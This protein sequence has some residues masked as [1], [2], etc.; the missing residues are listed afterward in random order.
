MPSPFWKSE[1][2]KERWYLGDTYN[3]SI[4]QGY[5]LV[6]PLQMAKAVL[7]FANGGSLCVPTLLKNAQPSCKK[8]SVS[9]ETLKLIREG[10][11]ETCTTGGTGWPL[12]DFRPATNSA[13]I[14]TG[15]KTGTA[16]S[17]AKSGNPHAWFTV[18]APFEKP[19]I[20]LTIL[21]EE[22]GQGSDVAAPIAKEILKTH[23]ERR[24]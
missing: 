15:C 19:E 6:T 7:P 5:T 12:F 24:E 13:A 11:R 3:T 8:L 1:V 10:M 9:Q 16:E 14:Q 17:H 2:L 4:G 20:A 22:G 18:F 23:F 21:V